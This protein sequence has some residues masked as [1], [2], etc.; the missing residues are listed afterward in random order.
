VATWG[1]LGYPS[2]TEEFDD[3]WPADLIIE[4]HDQTRGWFWSQLGM[5]TAA[6]G[7]VPYRQVLM[8]GFANDSEGRKMSKS[9]GNIVTPEEAIDRFGRDPLRAYLLSHNQHGEDL[10]FEW[11]GLGETQS[12]LNIFWN[13]FRF[14]LSYMELDDYDPADA[15]LDDGE[16]TVVDEW[17]LS[18]LQSVKREVDDAWTEYRV[19]DALNVVLE[20]V[21][22]DVSRFY[23][24]AIRERMWED[25]DSDSKRGAYA[26]LAVVLDEAVR[27]LAPFTPYITE[28]MYQRLDGEA[29]SV[30]ALATPEVDESLHQPE[31]EAEMAVLRQV[32]EAAA[33]AR[34]QGGRKLRW[35]V[36]RVVVE[37][38]DEDVRA[39]VDSLSELLSERVNARRVE[40]CETF[41]ELVEHAEPQM[42]VIGPEFGA[43]AQKVMN[44]V[45]GATR[46][47]VGDTL[48]VVVDGDEYELTA[49]MVEW[50]SEPPEHVSGA[51]FES[52]TVY[53][54]T[55]LTD[56]IEAEG[57]ARDVVRRIQEMRKRL[58]LAVDE[59]IHTAIEV[60]D[61][62]V[63]ALV[64]RHRD[65]IAEET[66]TE[67]FVD[68]DADET[69]DLV[70]EW[71]VE[72]ISVTIGIDRLE[73]AEP[74][75]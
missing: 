61:D 70:E 67:A 14:P 50:R 5:G 62:R 59:E 10:A 9:L 30:H 46:D 26:T 52:G 16:L 56:E 64:D 3:L 1:T 17:V 49:E 12:K 69:M 18:R 13:V 8:H 68:L 25:E 44:A 23:V 65:L 22:A 58:D 35:P 55:S 28:R 40:V 43:D 36:P 38:D 74:A 41:A 66:R 20:F 39:A 19:H 7:E 48:S 4:A 54:D 45:E 11:D 60:D 57:Y 27:L 24:K 31:L 6:V 21:T 71:D 29:T 37:S 51:D 42:G 47:E 75:A 73:A 53:V 63:A 32:E 34:Q 15:S 2:S 72:G 33:N